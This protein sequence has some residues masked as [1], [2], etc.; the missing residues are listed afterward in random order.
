MPRGKKKKKLNTKS[1]TCTYSSTSR[2][3]RKNSTLKYKNRRKRKQNIRAESN[4]RG[5]HRIWGINK[6]KSS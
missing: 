2:G 6:A 4:K 5:K 1:S 3:L